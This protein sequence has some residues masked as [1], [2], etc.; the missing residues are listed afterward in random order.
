[1]RYCVRG[2]VFAMSKSVLKCQF[3][4]SAGFAAK[5]SGKSSTRASST[6]A[7]CLKRAKAGANAKKGAI[8]ALGN[9]NVLGFSGL[10]A[11]VSV[12]NGN[13]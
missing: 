4:K 12:S 9:R 10:R 3:P 6:L 5:W 8:A 13:R 1:M 11:A 2:I 7:S